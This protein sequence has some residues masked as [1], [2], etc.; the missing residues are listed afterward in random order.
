[1]VTYHHQSQWMIHDKPKAYKISLML[2][3]LQ[4]KICECCLS[5]SKPILNIK[6]LGVK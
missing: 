5:D 3:K 4:K 1:M 6:V 2:Q